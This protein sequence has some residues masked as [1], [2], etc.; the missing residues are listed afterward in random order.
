[1]ADFV[2]ESFVGADATPIT[3]LDANWVATNTSVWPGSLQVTSNRIYSASGQYAGCYYNTTPPAADYE[4]SMDLYRDAGTDGQVQML[5]RYDPATG[6]GYMAGL[7]GYGWVG[8]HRIDGGYD[9][10]LITPVEVVGLDPGET[11]TLR[12]RVEGTTL[13]L[14][15]GAS[16]TPILSVTDA[17]Y[18][19]AGRV[20]VESSSLS[21]GLAGAINFTASELV[22]VPTQLA[23]PDADISAG[24]WTPSTG[25]TLFG[26][27]DE[28]VADNADYISTNSNSTAEIGLGPLVTP[29][30][31]AQTLTYRASGSSAKALKVGLYRGATLHEEWTTDPLSS[32]VTE[33]IRTLTTPMTDV[34]DVRVKVTAQDAASPPT[35]QIVF[36]A[37]GTGASGTTSCS[38]SYPTGIS[39]ATSELFC[40]VTGRSNT[41]NTA[42]TMPAGWTVVQDLEGGTGTWGVDAGTR[43]ETVFKKDAVTATETGTVTVSLAGTTANTLRASIIRVEKPA[44]YSLS[45]ES[46]TGADTTSDTSFSATGTT[47]LSFAPGDLLLIAVASAIDSATQSAQSITASGVT[48]GTRTNHASVAVTNGNDHRH[49]I[50]SVPVTAGTVSAAPTYSYTAS[51][52]TSGPAGFLR[53]RAVP[54][55]EF[56]RVTWIELEI[57]ESSSDVTAPVPTTPVATSTGTTTATVGATLNEATGTLYVVITE[58][59]NDG[60]PSVAQV[61]AGTDFWDATP[62]F[63]ANQAVASTGAKTF[64]ATGLTAGLTYRAYFVHTDAAN[65][66]ST[67]LES[68]SWTQPAPDGT[69]PTL[70]GSITVTAITQTTFTSE[71][72]AATDNVAV[73]GYE[74]SLNGGT[75]WID[76]GASRT[77]DATGMTPGALISLRWRAYDAAGNRSAFLSASVQME[78]P[79]VLGSTILLT[80]N[81][82]EHGPG[83][84]YPSIRTGDESKRYYFT[85]TRAPVNG[86]LDIDAAGV[87]VYTGTSDYFDFDLYENSVNLG[88]VR[89][90]LS[91]ASGVSASQVEVVVAVESSSSGIVMTATSPESVATADS[92][93]KVMV[94]LASVAESSTGSDSSTATKSA[95]ATAAEVTAV[96]ELVSA[97]QAQ[98]NQVLENLTSAD[99]ST[100]LMAA[101]AQLAESGVA[102]ETVSAVRAAVVALTEIVTAQEILS[103]QVVTGASQIEAGGITESLSQILS[104]TASAAEAGVATDSSTT[105]TQV[106]ADAQDLVLVMDQVYL[107]GELVATQVE[108]GVFEDS[109]ASSFGAEIKGSMMESVVVADSSVLTMYRTRTGRRY[110][111]LSPG[112][113]TALKVFLFYNVPKCFPPKP[114]NETAYLEIDLTQALGNDTA[115]AITSYEVTV[116]AGSDP[117]PEAVVGAPPILSPD[118]RGIMVPMV[119]GIRGVTYQ[120]EFLVARTSDGSSLVS[121]GYI[122]VL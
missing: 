103:T 41:A 73:T 107:E 70:T 115:A 12:F 2:V 37:I 75:S 17:T 44:G 63:A 81:T 71:C 22:S 111:I 80:T 25:S 64:N 85:I 100:A 36:G 31:G 93:T 91:F 79:G 119:G 120:W 1:M 59:P 20:G 14:F 11:V 57:P 42:P 86:T 84:M 48:F 26:V 101:V 77:H 29:D 61:K 46:S 47:N 24:A 117:N 49:I 6:N 4:L 102:G 51:A 109:L 8:I 105:A 112:T 118:G 106:T 104:A 3:T 30:A 108:A 116:L 53:L 122:T 40:I 38:P 33:Y 72:P 62:S 54:P 23:Y 82:G 5:A 10:S 60:P 95:G 113:A 39:A 32:A 96:S 43:R 18:A 74:V 50:D 27:L 9:T 92:S 76:K 28:A 121:I 89:A 7:L 52:A 67:V 99:V 66:N 15:V 19:A 83:I 21:T 34:S 13:S 114:F 88:S 45:V 55:T 94:A 56:A 87:F 69:P 78:H 35:T 16:T 90:T 68:A 98:I 97:V 110:V 58:Y 65:N